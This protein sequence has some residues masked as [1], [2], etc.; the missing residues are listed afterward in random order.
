MAKPEDFFTKRKRSG[1]WQFSVYVKGGEDAQ[2]LADAI[3][4]IVR[5]HAIKHGIALNKT[6]AVIK[7][8]L[9]QA[10]VVDDAENGAAK[11]GT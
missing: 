4:T 6:E 10:E 7:A 1:G 5:N 8:I 2:R 3:A 11:N 9:S